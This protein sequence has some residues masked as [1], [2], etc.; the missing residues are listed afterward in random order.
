MLRILVVVLILS[1]TAPAVLAQRETYL[2][3]IRKSAAK[4]WNALPADLDAWKK[5]PNHSILWGYNPPATPL[6]LAA[7]YGYL[8]SLNH[9][10]QY[11]QRAVAL[12][13]EYGSLRSTLPAD[14][15]SSRAEYSQGVP[16]LTPTGRSG[17]ARQ[18]LP[19]SARQ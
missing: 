18:S 3:E 14:F 11:A 6:Y 7:T 16:A 8:Y 13:A 9:D 1:S 4:T 17:R 2:A 5:N 15:A 10:E 12:L 19:L